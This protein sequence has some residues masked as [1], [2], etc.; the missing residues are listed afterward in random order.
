MCWV[1]VGCGIAWTLQTTEGYLSLR[2]QIASLLDILW[3][4]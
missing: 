3:D 4:V 2:P 1:W